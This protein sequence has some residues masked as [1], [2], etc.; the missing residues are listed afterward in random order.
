MHTTITTGRQ[1]YLPQVTNQPFLHQSPP[2]FGQIKYSVIIR[3]QGFAELVI[4][5]ATSRIE[6]MRPPQTRYLN[7][8]EMEAKLL[9]VHGLSITVS[10]GSWDFLPVANRNFRMTRVSQGLRPEKFS[11]FTFCSEPAM[12]LPILTEVPSGSHTGRGE[13][14]IDLRWFLS[15]SRKQKKVEEAWYHTKEFGSPSDT[16]FTARSK[17]PHAICT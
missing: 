9:G 13:F 2:I 10:V 17:A 6:G 16:D 3:P 4:G 11:N 5:H 12:E 8:R 1:A 15:H 14:H 7:R